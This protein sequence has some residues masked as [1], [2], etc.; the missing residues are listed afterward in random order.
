MGIVRTEEWLKG[1]ISEFF[2]DTHRTDQEIIE[3]F[4]R[5]IEY[6]HTLQN[7]LR[8]EQICILCAAPLGQS[9]QPD[10]KRKGQ[11][12]DKDCVKGE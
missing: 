9:H 1:Q 4:D 2:G 7:C 5:T 8:K 10:C 6:I 11:V 3:A 12:T